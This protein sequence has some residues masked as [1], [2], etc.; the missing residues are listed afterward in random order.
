MSRIGRG[1]D[2]R[3]TFSTIKLNNIVLDRVPYDTSAVATLYYFYTYLSENLWFHHL[4]LFP[5]SLAHS[6]HFDY[7][8]SDLSLSEHRIAAIAKNPMVCHIIFIIFCT[9]II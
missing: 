5:C 1:H 9:R 3:V 4:G 8:T 7:E 2:K 6:S